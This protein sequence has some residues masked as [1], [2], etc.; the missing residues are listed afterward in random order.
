MMDTF[1]DFWAVYPLRVAKK[2]ARRAWE[3]LHPSPDLQQR[4]AAALA[5]QVPLWASQGY[6]TPYP[7]TYLNGERWED[8]PP[9]PARPTARRAASY[10]PA[11][12][13]EARQARARVE[14]AR[15][16]GDA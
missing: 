13:E 5:W 1:D 8:E 11:W 12:A 6:G 2:D 14:A 10:E 3:K 16:G 7:A 15:R 4:I 9:A